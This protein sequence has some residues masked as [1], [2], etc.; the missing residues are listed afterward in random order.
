MRPEPPAVAGR[1][2][3]ILVTAGTFIR[4]RTGGRP[5]EGPPHTVRLRAFYIDATLVTRA[6]FARFAQATGYATTA[7]RM[8]YGM[9]SEEGMDDWAWQRVPHGSWRRPF[10]RET[11]DAAA[12]L[13]DDAPVVMVTFA[14][15]VAFCAHAGKRLPTE[16]EWEYAMRAGSSGTRYPWGDSAEREP[17]KVGLNYWQGESH[18]AN[19]REDGHVYVSPVRAF[20]PNAWGIYD[21]VGNVWQW[22]SDFYAADTYAR[23]SARAIVDDPRGPEAGTE[24]VLRGGSW[25]CGSCTCEGNGLFYR[26]HAS[27]TAPFNNN[28]FRCARDAEATSDLRRP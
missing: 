12:F 17:G 2:E 24:R 7:E 22:T 27:P 9:G 5:D 18:H 28:G 3:M 26:G 16:A 8:G 21:P 19:T 1:E 14:D 15:A 4:G 10:V 6:A 23:T 13:R 11:A 20:P 25:W